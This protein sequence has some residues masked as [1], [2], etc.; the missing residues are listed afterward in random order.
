MPPSTTTPQGAAAPL[1]RREG[2]DRP[3]FSVSRQATLQ[4]VGRL[5][6]G[7]RRDVPAAVGAVARLRRE[8][9]RLPFAEPTSWGLDDA[10]ELM[11]VRQKRLREDQERLEGKATDATYFSSAE[12]R[13]R[14]K[15]EQRE[16]IAVHLAV[17]LWALHQQSLRD[18][19]MHLRG[20]PLGRAVRRLAH[21]GTGTRDNP[22]GPE[23]TSD[24]DSSS[25]SAESPVEE[26]SETIRKRFVRIGASSD[27]D[28]LARRL[29]EMVLLLRGA[30]IP[31]DYGLLAEQLFQWQ[32]ENR[33]A[34]TCRA[35]GR[36]FHT[37]Y[38][39][40][41]ADPEEDESGTPPAAGPGDA[42]SDRDD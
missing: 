11:K 20:W 24:G 14:E 37:L 27:V 31:L 30:R 21:G 18:E 10:E 8:A 42:D 2:T 17:T 29:R 9:G 3:S 39:N 1:R 28:V 23:G 5:Q 40:E 12:I 38:R 26:A 16:E 34:E 6:A 7:Y 19:P 32:N 35:W 15:S 4:T 41:T 33:R 36:A 22:R 25:K 13:R